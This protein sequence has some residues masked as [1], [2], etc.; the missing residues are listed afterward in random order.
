MA[1]ER[2]FFICSVAF[3]GII[4][5]FLFHQP[6]TKADEQKTHIVEET[7]KN[8]ELERPEPL[9]LAQGKISVPYRFPNKASSVQFLS[10]GKRVDVIFTSKENMALSSVS[11]MLLKN[12]QVLDIGDYGK[13]NVNEP[14]EIMLEMTPRESEIFSYAQNSGNI[15]LAITETTSSGSNPLAQSLLE[16]KSY[17]NFNS[18]L[19]TH[20][21]RSLFPTVDMKVTSTLKGYIVEGLVK[22]PRT[23]EN[24]LKTLDMLSSGGSKTVINLMEEEWR[25]HEANEPIFEPKI[26]GNVIV[27]HEFSP[28]AL[29]IQ[30]LKPDMHVDVKYSFKMDL[31]F[32]TD[33]VPLI[34]NVR[35]AAV[36]ELE[37]KKTINKA[38]SKNSRP[39]LEIYL[40]MS[41]RQAEIY[42]YALQSGSVTFML[43]ADD[44]EQDPDS[45]VNRLLV[46][47][48]TG[49]FH[50]ALVT[51]MVRSLFPGV[52]VKVTE[53]HNGYIVEGNVPAP[54]VA[55]KI[56]EILQR[57]TP[58]G[59][60]G[61]ISLLEIDPQQVLINVRVFEIAKSV[62]ARLG[63]NWKAIFQNDGASAIYSA[64]Y[65]SPPAT[66]PNFSINASGIRFGKWSLS[67][68]ID[69]LEEDGFLRI[70]AEPNLT[71]VSGT[72]AHF[73]AGG[74]FPILVPQGGTLLGTVTVEY[75]KYGVLLDFT[76]RVDI[77]GLI[78]MH[79]VPEVSNIDKE[80]SVVIQG[81][82]IPSLVTR[83]VD[84]IVKLWPG[85][86]YLIAGL[87]QNQMLDVNDNLFGLDRLPIIGPIFSSKHCEDRRTELIVVIT[88]YL[89]NNECE[90]N[91]NQTSECS[92]ALDE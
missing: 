61:I 64:V 43:A 45:L 29:T 87:F 31:G 27:P 73:F 63:I 69:L 42:M 20:V 53:S 33:G 59:Q 47:G 2:L 1:K 67:T 49:Q 30:F 76:P 48:S 46:S 18:I 36:K 8:K 72:T 28:D 41:P 37:N 9:P 86:S 88:P 26:N 16:S 65:P 92:G 5:A 21:M 91:E 54:Q 77:N 22:D 14:V 34:R 7:K 57:L 56:L 51:H 6:S 55:D 50:S 40:E 10:P 58:A 11:L 62:K 24:I 15:S 13:Q 81:F 44:P 35:V 4:A 85:Q 68:L 23:S 17:E 82:V 60:K 12:L 70:L 39:N 78:T 80:N 52:N 90:A 84:T 25:G 89:I 66:D 79:V 3:L 75:K 38:D 71:T 74:E 32:G 19:I 83:R